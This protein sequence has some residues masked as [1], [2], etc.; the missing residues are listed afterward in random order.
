LSELA[1]VPG[2]ASRPAR[3]GPQL[4]PRPAEVSDGPGAWW[5]RRGATP[6]PTVP[7]ERVRRARA[8]GLPSTPVPASNG[9]ASDGADSDGAG[10]DGPEVADSVLDDRLPMV[11]PRPAAVLCALFEEDGDTWV[12]LTRRS[13]R[14]RTHTGEV[15]FPGGRLD[16]GE[17]PVAAALREA[18]E[19]VGIN[20]AAVEVIGELSPLATM[21][22]RS[23]ITPFVGVLPRRPHLRP[24]PAEVD[25]AFAVPLSGLMAPGVYHEER[26][27]FASGGDRAIHF[28]DV[29]G[30]TVWGATAKMLRNLLDLTYPAPV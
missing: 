12:V 16:A 3:A 2:R 8:A 14:L 24:N 5:S 20:P 29:P 4:I 10:W 25:R 28:F 15:A 1:A 9:A 21:S 7:L 22:S 23:A 27:G 30:D 19:E 11:D 13:T 18:E 6:P 17:T 26:W